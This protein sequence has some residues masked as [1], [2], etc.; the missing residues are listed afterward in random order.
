[1][2]TVTIEPADNGLIKH[3]V[4]DNVNGGGEEHIA[5]RVYDFEG[6]EA[7]ENQI[8]FFYDMIL[9]LGVDIGTDL[10]GDKLSISTEWGS[11]YKPTAA[12]IEQ[13]VK[14]LEAEIKRLSTLK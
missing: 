8:K 11:K 13:R 2:I 4:D 9:D 7:R 3:V 6:I 5:R 10:D 12:E 1:M 14:E